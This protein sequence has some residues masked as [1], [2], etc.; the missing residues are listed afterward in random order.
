MLVKLVKCKIYIII[1]LTIQSQTRAHYYA[2]LF[3]LWGGILMKRTIILPLICIALFLFIAYS[4][5]GRKNKKDSKSKKPGRSKKPD[6]YCPNTDKDSESLSN[7]DKGS[8]TQKD[9]IILARAINIS[10]CIKNLLMTQEKIATLFGGFFY[11]SS[12]NFLIFVLLLGK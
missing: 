1:I 9:T 12:V 10:F 8:E 5:L 6:Q 2:S 11:F 4:H 3:F 7:T